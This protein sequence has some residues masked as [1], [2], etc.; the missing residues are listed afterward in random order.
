MIVAAHQTMLAPQGAPLGSVV[1]S[2]QMDSNLV[3]TDSGTSGP[4]A[5][6]F[7]AWVK[8]AASP[9]RGAFVKVGNRQV[10][11]TP[12][13]GVGAGFGSTRFDP[14]YSGSHVVGL[15][16]SVAWANSS[17]DASTIA[18]WH[19]YAVT[20]SGYALSVYIDG[21]LFW[22]KTFSNVRSMS[23]FVVYI[24][25]NRGGG[26]GGDTNRFLACSM[27][28][29]AYWSRALSASEVAADCADGNSAP[30]TTSGLEHYWPMSSAT[31]YLA[32]AVGSATLT[33]GTGGVTISTDTPFA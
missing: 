9:T 5:F 14:N 19:H 12:G 6:T 29:S 22:T 28:R 7:S 30:S 17:T 27:T 15:A 21:S 11:T 31:N 33:A 3:W 23:P 25:G 1:F 2:G 4:G 32:D 8:A 20:L 10:G 18:S 26:S 24:G 13:A 16:E